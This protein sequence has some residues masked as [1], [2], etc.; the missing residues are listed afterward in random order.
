LL[1]NKTLTAIAGAVTTQSTSGLPTF[2]VYNLR[3]GWNMLTTALTIDANET[4]SSTATTAAVIDTAS[5]HNVVTTAD[6]LRIDC[7]VNGTGTKGV[8]IEMT[9]G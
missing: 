2:N 7:S 3:G 6:Q 8:I 9:F 1:N 4:D 5:S